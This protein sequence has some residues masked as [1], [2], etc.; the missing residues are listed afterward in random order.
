[1]AA[2]PVCRWLRSLEPSVA[3]LGALAVQRGPSFSPTRHQLH[4]RVV[5]ASSSPGFQAWG[6]ST[7]TI[8]DSWMAIGAFPWAGRYLPAHRG[9]LAWRAPLPWET[10]SS[11]LSAWRESWLNL[12]MHSLVS[13]AET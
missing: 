13:V 4:R 11:V 12:D 3:L 5:P 10:R 1:M 7:L 6:P 2:T 9:P 8:D